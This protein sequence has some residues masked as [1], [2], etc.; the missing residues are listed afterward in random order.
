[1][2]NALEY[3]IS[4]IVDNPKEVVILQREEN[5]NIVFE[6]TVA[7]DDMGKIIGKS[8]K[9]IKSI[10]NVMKIPAIKN[11]KKINITLTETPA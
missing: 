9:V 8:G 6:V 5:G 3:I 4:A 7:K 11:G 1:M 2:K 10:R